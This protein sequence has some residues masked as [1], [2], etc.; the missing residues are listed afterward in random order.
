MSEKK[1]K[2]AKT[3]KAPKAPRKDRN[4]D[5]MKRMGSPTGAYDPFSPDWWRWALYFSDKPTDVLVAMVTSKTVAFGHHWSAFA[6]DENNHDL[7][8]R[9]L[10]AE[11]ERIRPDQSW[12]DQKYY[13]RVMRNA[14]DEG[15]LRRDA[16]RPGG[17]EIA[18]RKIYLCAIIQ[19]VQAI[20]QRVE[21]KESDGGLGIPRYSPDSPYIRLRPS[22]IAEQLLAMP[23]DIRFSTE[24]WLKRKDEWYRGLHAEALS[25]VETFADQVERSKL[26]SLG[27]K[28]F[29]ATVNG[30]TRGRPKTDRGAQLDLLDWRVAKT[31]HLDL[32]LTSI[33]ESLATP[34]A[35]IPD[36]RA[37]GPPLDAPV[38]PGNNLENT[39]ETGDTALSGA[40]TRDTPPPG[41]ISELFPNSLHLIAADQTNVVS[42]R[43][44][45]ALREESVS[46]Q[47]DG[48]VNA[49]PSPPLATPQA[50]GRKTPPV[51]VAAHSSAPRKA[52]EAI[53]RG[54]QPK[55]ES[56][57]AEARERTGLAGTPSIEARARRSAIAAAV[58]PVMTAR[59]GQ[60]LTPHLV[61]QI[62]FL[63]RGAPPSHFG[64]RLES[65]WRARPEYFTSLGLLIRGGEHGEGIAGDVGR[66]WA[67]GAADR[68]ADAAKVA[69]RHHA[70][71]ERAG[72]LAAEE[73]KR[74]HLVAHPE[75]CPM[76]AGSGKYSTDVLP[77]EL[78]PRVAERRVCGCP[79][80]EALG[81]GTQ[82]LGVGL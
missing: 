80:G 39:D 22:H 68:E 46:P 14:E 56:P 76:C 8:L 30:K 74:A 19:S 18:R 45:S 13:E 1:T 37:D 53:P 66:A 7:T 67:A 59:A 5:Q 60:V 3:A 55:T 12:H 73:R 38:G 63:L 58:P 75:A 20:L 48:P 10:A 28:Y 6:V 47:T 23:D 50:G 33:P 21:N 27:V 17:I 43:D 82:G 44:S 65:E 36:A 57:A 64:A 26:Q 51:R 72:E 29:A 78:R 15:R 24:N 2:K 81:S 54:P 32:R 69:R 40:G 42:S 79:A 34:G 52:A 35:E 49:P 70:D 4:S 41:N 16:Y 11:L 61:R 9:E 62:E 77:A 31:P 25:A 71:Q